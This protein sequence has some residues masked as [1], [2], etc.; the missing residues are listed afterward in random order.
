MFDL[1]FFPCAV[2]IPNM[3]RRDSCKVDCKND[4][5]FLEKNHSYSVY[6]NTTIACSP[7]LKQVQVGF[8]FACSAGSQLSL[9][10]PELHV[11][12]VA[13]YPELVL[14]AFPALNSNSSSGIPQR[15]DMHTRRSAAKLS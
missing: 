14:H 13:F 3:T 15:K 4:Y 7:K 9:V 10:S 2:F 11:F 5:F 8:F 12:L 1:G 6:N